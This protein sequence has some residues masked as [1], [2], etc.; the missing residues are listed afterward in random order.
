MLYPALGT[1]D[2]VINTTVIPIYFNEVF[3]LI[4]KANFKQIIIKI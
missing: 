2:M 1:V 3:S 4:G